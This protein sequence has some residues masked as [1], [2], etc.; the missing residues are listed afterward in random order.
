[1]RKAYFQGARQDNR[2]YAVLIL[3]ESHLQKYNLDLLDF[4]AQW[5]QIRATLF[6]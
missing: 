4:V 3:L 5:N 1:M 6:L 2:T